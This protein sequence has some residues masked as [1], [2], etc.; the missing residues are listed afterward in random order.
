METPNMNTKYNVKIKR[1][2]E[3]FRKRKDIPDNNKNLI[4]KFVEK[5]T[6]E[7]IGTRRV[8]KYF[9]VLPKYAVWLGKNLKET[10]Q[11]DIVRVMGIL[12]TSDYKN[13]TKSSYK[14]VIK[15][16]Y[17]WLYDD[18]IPKFIRKI[19]SNRNNGTKKSSD[20]LSPGD[21]KRLLQVCVNERDQCLIAILWDTGA[22]IGELIDLKIKDVVFKENMAYVS[23]YAPKTSEARTVPIIESVPYI[24]KWIE[25]HPNR[26]DNEYI[27]VNV[28]KKSGQVLSH[29]GVSRILEKIKEKTGI[30]KPCNAHQFRH[31]RATFMANRL[32]EAQMCKYFGWTMGS[33]MPATYV[34]LSGRDINDAILRMHG[35]EVKEE[36]K[37]TLKP[38]KCLRCDFVSPPHADQCHRC[39]LPFNI[40]AQME[41][42]KQ[43]ESFMKAIQVDRIKREIIE[44]I[45]RDITCK[46][47]Y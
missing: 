24:T 33:D 31:S 46:L 10:N 13:W 34:H 44:E 7:G 6:S 17:R 45:K 25:K 39:G 14:A 2:I 47:K 12:E 5:Q 22:R 40:E 4:L 3:I 28:G 8:L 36:R 26:K 37:E 9:V 35:H 38:V 11:D 41:F 30:T 15:T 19:K 29:G 32:T 20:M 43:K 21:I 16:F 1:A 27:F 23:I 18:D 42:Q